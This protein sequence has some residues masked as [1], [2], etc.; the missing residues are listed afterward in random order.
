MNEQEAK[1]SVHDYQEESTR[2]AVNQV[3]RGEV[4]EICIRRH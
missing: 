2:C 4:R 1:L 3:L